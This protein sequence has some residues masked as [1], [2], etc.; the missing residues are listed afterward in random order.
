M[1]VSLYLS[2]L[3]TCVKVQENEFEDFKM[4]FH[5]ESWSFMGVKN[6]WAKGA[7]N[8]PYSNQ[9]FLYFWKCFET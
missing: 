6:L 9:A 2:E 7:N 4:D 1:K 5:F 3:F 8:K